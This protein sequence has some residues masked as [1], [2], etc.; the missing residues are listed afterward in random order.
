MDVSSWVLSRA[1]P[2]EAQR[3]HE[4][5]AAAAT[6]ADDTARRL[7]LGDLADFPTGFLP[8]PSG[9]PSRSRPVRASIR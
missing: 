2:S 1:L 5:V 8:A 3:F 4:L 6:T 7:A 9:A